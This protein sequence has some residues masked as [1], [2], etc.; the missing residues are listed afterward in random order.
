VWATIPF[1]QA[2]SQ[3]SEI[4]RRC[5][6]LFTYAVFNDSFN[7]SDKKRHMMAW[8]VNSKRAEIRKETVRAN[9]R[10]YNGLCLEELRKNTKSLS[11]IGRCAELIFESG[12]TEHAAGVNVRQRQFIME[13]QQS[14]FI[15]QI[16]FSC[17]ILKWQCSLVGRCFRGML[18][19]LC[20]S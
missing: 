20:S 18:A 12:N 19:T 5:F 17:K 4:T 10:Y 9:L 1:L 16:I 13:R 11:Q 14:H 2:D 8:L 3:A 6:L 15:K 7:S